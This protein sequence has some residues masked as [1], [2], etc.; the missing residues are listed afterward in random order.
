[1]V[2]KDPLAND[3]AA[4]IDAKYS[5]N[6]DKENKMHDACQNYCTNIFGNPRHSYNDAEDDIDD[7]EY[8][9]RDDE[10]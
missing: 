3:D 10:D 8:E 1:M 4:T 9:V 6:K 5:Y 2:K 7:I